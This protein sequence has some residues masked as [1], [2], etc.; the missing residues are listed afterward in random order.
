LL[1]GCGGGAKA[2]P[3]TTPKLLRQFQIIFPEGFTRAQ[4]ADRVTAVAQI[5]E[6]KSHLPVRISE[7]A[8]LAASRP[9]VIPGFGPDKLATE[10]FLFPNTYN[11]DRRSTSADL[12]NAQLQEF[13]KEWR[14]V[15]MSYAQSKN[16]TPYDVLTLASIIQGEIAVPSENKLAAAV[17]YNRLH[18]G[19]TLGSDA[20]LAYGLHLK[21]GQQLT[22]SQLDSNSP[23][24]VLKFHGLPPTPINNPGIAAIQAAA[25]PANVDYLYFLRKP[26]SKHTY[27]TASYQDFLDHK[28]QYGY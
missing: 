2:A 12:V 21:P 9:Q 16:L 18:L 4:M 22:Q 17:F 27:F 19:M 28:A 1:A 25:H 6:N 3:P 20:V 5:A 26:H 10:G 13:Q 24:N 7:Q 11:F 8:Y 23:Y 14:T 15:D